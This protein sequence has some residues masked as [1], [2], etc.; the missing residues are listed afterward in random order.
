M[1]QPKL[2]LGEYYQLLLKNG[3]LRH[4]SPLPLDF[5][6]RV[7][8]VCCDSKA[9]MPGTL[10]I[11]KGAA[12]R[13]EYLREAVSR[14]AF[15]YVSEREYPQS[16]AGAF[17]LE[18]TDVRTA[19]AL[20]ADRAW[21]HPSGRLK[22]VGITGTKGKTTVAYYLRSILDAWGEGAGTALL[23]TILTDD[24][25]SAGPPS[26]PPPSPW[27]SSATSLTPSRRGGSMLSWRSPVRPSSTAGCWGPSSRWEPSSTSGRTISAP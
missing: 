15:V 16:E 26:S 11:C 18:V 2:P 5:T 7:S 8:Q 10:F 14:G 13:E 19:M 22:V 23:S 20:L 6:R 1:L 27:S 3:L 21:G 17:C 25:V 24:G 4:R 12:F 9:V